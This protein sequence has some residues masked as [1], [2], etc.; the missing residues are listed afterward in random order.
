MSSTLSQLN[1]KIP[2]DVWGLIFSHYAAEESIWDPLET[3][4]LVCKGWKEV[5]LGYCALWNEL[6][7]YIGHNPTS[8]MWNTRLPLRLARSG[9]TIPLYI[10]LRNYL[11][12]PLSERTQEDTQH[13]KIYSPK[14]CGPV[15]R[16]VHHD[17]READPGCACSTAAKGASR[18]P[19]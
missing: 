17:F 2:F 5:A 9:P 1:R 15:Y 4:L 12:I 19:C 6:N 13:D 16:P 7:I 14:P 18:P 11:A 8:Q 10:R 3:L